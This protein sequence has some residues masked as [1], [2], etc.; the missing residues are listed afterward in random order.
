VPDAFL[1]FLF[2]GSIEKMVIDIP[3]KER[4]FSLFFEM[5]QTTACC[6]RQPARE[7]RKPLPPL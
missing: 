3:V 7:T 4:P 6:G 1:F 2:P 5:Q